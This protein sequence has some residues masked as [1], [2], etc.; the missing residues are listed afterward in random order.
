[1]ALQRVAIP[2]PNYS[3][4]G[5]AAV[6]LIVLHTAEGSRTYQSLG[7]YF[8]NPSSGVS[9]HVG[10]DDTAN[11]IGE[12]VQRDWK[13][14][15]QAN[16]NPVAC[17]AEICA[18]AAWDSA[19][20]HR[21]PNMLSNAA[22]WL[23]E[24]AAHFNIPLVSL[25][26]QQAQGGGRGVC[27]HVDLGSWGG[28]HVDCGP[29]FPMDEVIAMAGGQPGTAPSPTPPPSQPAGKAP[30]FPYPS[31][32]YLGRPDPD[33]HCHSGHYGGVDST[34]VHT[35]QAQM[36]AR[37]W[38]IGVDGDYGDQSYNICRQFQGEKGLAV[39]GLVGPTTWRTTWEAPVT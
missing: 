36:K 30:A 32:H 25:T 20:W 19:E 24:E 13:A 35:W 31:D 26:P 28:G 16:A 23:A 2:S 17:A 6:R 9:S 34:N 12:Y 14:W 5:G 1:M 38:A 3:S 4:R 7:S 27:D 11:Q 8:Q 10:I 37:G 29:G 15:T 21:H 39:D 22:A 33:P 18:F